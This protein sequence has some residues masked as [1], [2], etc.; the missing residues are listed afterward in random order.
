MPIM[1]K[2]T[3]IFPC[4]K[5][6]KEHRISL[7]L[8]LLL[9]ADFVFIAL[10]SIN[11]L[12]TRL[13]NPSFSIEKDGS[14]PELY[15]YFKWFLIIVLLIQVSVMRKSLSYIAWVLVFTYFLCDDALEIH[16]TIGNHI[17]RKFSLTPPFGLRRLDL[18]ELAVSAIA[19]IILLSF[20]I[21][22]Y[23]HGSSAFK[24]MSRDMLLLIIALVFFGVVVDMVHIAIQSDW[25]VKFI[26]GVIED[27]GEMLV[28]SLMLWYV[29][30]LTVRD[31]N[32]SLYLCDTMYVILARRV[33]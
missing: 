17:A 9:F 14:Y 19:A 3:M 24:K 21:Q 30:Q 31:E 23:R 29:F 20:V 22:A 8:L 15:Q 10:H 7:F 5:T 32:T 6:V 11:F 33:T 26:L 18:G 12:S 27:G 13:N 4:M 2:K 28:A 25:K 16:E 1:N